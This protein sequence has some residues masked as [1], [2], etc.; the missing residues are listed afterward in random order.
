MKESITVTRWN[1]AVRNVANKIGV[2]PV[3]IKTVI[4]DLPRSG[5]AKQVRAEIKRL[6]AEGK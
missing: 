5:I 4:N 1:E 3:I 2:W 6:K